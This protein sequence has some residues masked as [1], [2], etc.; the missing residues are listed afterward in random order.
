M[1]LIT[2]AIGS[3]MC[4]RSG[5]E[6]QMNQMPLG[7]F[8][9]KSGVGVHE[10]IEY[11][12]AVGVVKTASDGLDYREQRILAE[13]FKKGPKPDLRVKEHFVAE[14]S[15]NFDCLPKHFIKLIKTREQKNPVEY[16]HALAQSAL[17]Y[18]FHRDVEPANWLL[19]ALVAANQDQL[20][21]W[22]RRLGLR[23]KKLLVSDYRWPKKLWLLDPKQK[24]KSRQRSEIHSYLLEINFLVRFDSIQSQKNTK[25]DHKP[26]F[27]DLEKE[28]MGKSIRALQGGAAGLKR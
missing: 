24:L 13:R 12:L 1:C 25:A 2:T 20:V 26:W 9:L 14:D 6:F 8:A 5:S 27:D 19:N 23:S 18:A 28:A 10:L 11:L 15:S 17:G 16:A 3:A 21:R 22:F 7:V 4:R